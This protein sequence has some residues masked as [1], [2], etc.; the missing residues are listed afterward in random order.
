LGYLPADLL[1]VNNSF[2]GFVLLGITSSKMP[3]R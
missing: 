2:S 3:K 1:P